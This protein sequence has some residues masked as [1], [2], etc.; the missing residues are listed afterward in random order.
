MRYLLLLPI[1]LV[2]ACSTVNPL[3]PSAVVTV[4][5]SLSPDPNPNAI[6][7]RFPI[8][9]PPGNHYSECQLR[10]L[11]SVRGLQVPDEGP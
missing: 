6:H 11:A 5:P 4:T 1:L 7:R 2:S 3:A 10:L 9:C 8:L